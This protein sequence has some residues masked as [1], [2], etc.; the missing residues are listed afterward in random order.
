M[1]LTVDELRTQHAAIL[2]L[3]VAQLMAAKRSG[4]SDELDAALDSLVDFRAMT[5]FP[6]LQLEAAKARDAASSEIAEVALEELAKISD[7]ATAAGAGFKAAA[8]IAESGKKE[9]LFPA[10]AATAARG[11]ELIRQFQ[12]A[13]DSVKENVDDVEELGDVP[14]ALKGVV[15]AVTE[16]K[17]K[18]EAAE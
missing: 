11:L 15:D 6:G 2:E 5:P 18:I 16:L 13:I 14:D 17:K 9:L 1:A 3:R 4:D 7:Q 8:M 12:A 10:L